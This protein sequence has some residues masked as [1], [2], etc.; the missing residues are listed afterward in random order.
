MHACW[1]SHA[2]LVRMC[3]ARHGH[4]GFG[5]K[6]NTCTCVVHVAMVV[7]EMMLWKCPPILILAVLHLIHVEDLKNDEV[8]VSCLGV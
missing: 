1:P 2:L 7:A 8:W 6:G 5:P 4:D 3:L